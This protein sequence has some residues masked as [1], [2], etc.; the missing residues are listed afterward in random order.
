MGADRE[1][2]HEKEWYSFSFLLF[3]VF[4]FLWDLFFCLVGVIGYWLL[5]IGMSCLL[6]VGILGLVLLVFRLRDGII[7]AVLLWNHH[8][9]PFT[10]STVLLEFPGVFL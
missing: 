2:R 5:V 1:E 7:N 8:A 3:M 4:C 10:W 6:L 9:G